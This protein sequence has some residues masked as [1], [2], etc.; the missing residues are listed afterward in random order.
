MNEHIVAAASYSFM[1]E[2][3]AA[4]HETSSQYSVLKTL[5][6]CFLRDIHD[7][8]KKTKPTQQES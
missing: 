7:G 8:E 6:V 2:V 3:V 5:T 4:C 1:L